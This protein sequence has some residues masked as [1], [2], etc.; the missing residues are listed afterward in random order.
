MKLLIKNGT[1]VLKDKE[2][3]ADLLVED[4]KIAKIA[5][6]ISLPAS[7]AGCEVIDAKGKHII[8][9]IIDMHVHLREPG[10]E[11]KEDIASG[12]R[13]MR[14]VDGAVYEIIGEPENIGM[15]G[16]FLKCRV[17]RVKGGA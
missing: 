8:A 15:R 17:R 14:A 9:G 11:G 7:S 3:K 1:L 16:Q 12:C 2:I 4:G 13:I 10:F 5:E 6:K